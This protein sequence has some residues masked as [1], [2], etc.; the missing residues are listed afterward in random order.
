[1]LN[2]RN[3]A[4]VLLDELDAPDR[5]K[6]HVRLVG[7]AADLLI[8]KFTELGLPIDFNF[9][10]IAVAVHDIGKIKYTNEMSGPGSEHEPEGEKI[11]LDLGADPKIAR[12]C[13]SHSR[14]ST[15]ECSIEELIIALSDKLW[16]GKRVEELEL[17]VIDACAALTGNDRWDMFSELDHHFELIAEGG[18]KRL[19]RSVSI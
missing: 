5:L 11:L 1:M 6:T 3:D 7:E 12:C 15:M 16:K 18:D 14:F 13:M 2:S 19:Q 8:E 9:I 17:E 4:Y 10:R